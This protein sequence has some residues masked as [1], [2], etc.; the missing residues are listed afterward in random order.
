MPKIVIE[1]SKKEYE[2]IKALDYANVG[3]MSRKALVYAALQSIKCGTP[4]PK[5]H[6]V[7]ISQK[8]VL[9]IL[10]QDGVHFCDMVKITSDI[11][12]LPGIEADREVK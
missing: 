4:L 1:L 10:T 8:A 12:E 3:R 7:L 6:D 11:K 5:G 2:G 9:D